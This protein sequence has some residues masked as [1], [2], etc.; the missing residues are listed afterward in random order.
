[1]EVLKLMKKRTKKITEERKIIPL[2]ISSGYSIAFVVMLAVYSNIPESFNINGFV[3]YINGDNLSDY[4]TVLSIQFTTVFLT[5][6]LMSTLGSEKRMVYYEDIVKS[7]LLKPAGG[8]FKALSVYA[9]ISLFWSVVAFVFRAAYLVVFATATGIILVSFLFFKMIDIYF[10]REKKLVKNREDLKK[11]NVKKDEYYKKL[12]KLHLVIKENITERQV[13]HLV[14]NM[15][16]LIELY[17]YYIDIEGE[18]NIWDYIIDSQYGIGREVRKA[19]YAKCF[20]D[21]TLN[22]IKKAQDISE[23]D[24]CSKIHQYFLDEIEDIESNKKH[25]QRLCVLKECKKYAGELV[26]QCLHENR[27]EQD[28]RTMYIEKI[29]YK[30][31]KVCDSLMDE[32]MLKLNN[33][34]SEEDYNELDANA[35]KSK[36]VEIAEK[37]FANRVYRTSG[38][39]AP[40]CWENFFDD[41]DIMIKKD[42]QRIQ[43]KKV[44]CNDNYDELEEGW[45][46]YFLFEENKNA[47]F[48]RILAR[49]ALKYSGNMLNNTFSSFYYAYK[50][51]ACGGKLFPREEYREVYETMICVFL[52]GCAEM[53]MRGQGEPAIDIV[54]DIIFDFWKTA[55]FYKKPEELQKFY[56]DTFNIFGSRLLY[57]DKTGGNERFNEHPEV[58]QKF[59]NKLITKCN[60]KDIAVDDSVR[61]FEAN[62]VLADF[63]ACLE[64]FS[65]KYYSIEMVNA[66]KKMVQ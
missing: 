7:I 26:V 16:L 43:D 10:G 31:Y 30:E 9:F 53:I 63:I 59:I 64:K 57:V 2:L 65:P 20:L 8:N 29:I 60:R 17:K 52:Q 61:N 35:E 40:S 18:G 21:N 32:N 37:I 56:K 41:I 13:T 5:T 14:E 51:K 24:I 58:V 3:A 12:F 27:E 39:L 44:E 62:V 42:E 45:L 50:N 38:L 19:E 11:E 6:G 23:L 49:L 22:E 28:G 66:I 55:Q 34:N 33:L 15:S 54:G 25:K 4:L 47:I 46:D 36:Y 1:M 48:V